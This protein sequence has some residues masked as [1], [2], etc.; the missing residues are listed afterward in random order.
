MVSAA[1]IVLF[2]CLVAISIG[3]YISR[4]RNSKTSTELSEARS[5]A[6]A[7]EA[8]AAAALES[9]DVR[10]QAAE[11]QA[12]A[13]AANAILKM[14]NEMKPVAPV[15]PV[16]APKPEKKVV[17]Y[18]EIDTTKGHPR[19]Y[20]SHH[21]PYGGTWHTVSPGKAQTPEACWEHATRNKLSNWGWRSGDKSCW[22]YMD[23]YLWSGGGGQSSHNHIGGCTQPGM[24]LDD[25]CMDFKKGDVVIGHKGGV[26]GGYNNYAGQE[27]MTFKKCR[28]LAAKKGIRTFGYRTNRHPDSNWSNTCFAPNNADNMDGFIGSGGDHAHLMACTNPGKMM[29]DDCR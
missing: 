6:A 28:L 1:N 20:G 14:K 4:K 16:A 19:G 23:A 21:V 8:R 26:A 12:K 2:L 13:D 27:K 7:A 10:V 29:V 9:A 24:K 22:S 3:F 5:K 25:G 11:A 15:A 17:T 18:A